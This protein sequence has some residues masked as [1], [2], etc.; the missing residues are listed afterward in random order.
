M[1]AVS[2][3]PRSH[4]EALPSPTAVDLFV[5]LLK[6]VSVA[7]LVFGIIL[8]SRPW[9]YVAGASGILSVTLYA[10]SQSGTDEPWGKWIVRIALSTLSLKG[11][12]AP[13]NQ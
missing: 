1:S 12:E 13:K 7:T 5:S 2:Q 6:I 4:S 8:G 10:Y 3:L 11:I 9:F